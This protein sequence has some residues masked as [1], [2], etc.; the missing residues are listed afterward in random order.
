MESI[1]RGYRITTTP[2]QG[3][4][5]VCLDATIQ[6]QRVASPPPDMPALARFPAPQ[7]VDPPPHAVREIATALADAKNPLILIG[8]VSNDRAAFAQRVELAERLNARVLTDLKTAASF[9]TEHPLHPFAAGLYVS[10][11]AGAMIRE[12][13][14]IL[15]LD[16]IDLGGSL[17]QACAGGFPSAKILQCSM[18]SYSHKGWSM[19][20]QA[21]P[22]ADTLLL[23]S[24][25]RLVN[26]LLE[27]VP[28]K[29]LRPI[30]APAAA[31]AKPATTAARQTTVSCRLS[32]KSACRSTPWHASLQTRS[33]ASTLRTSACHWGGLASIADLPIRS[34]SSASMVAAESVQDR[35]WPSAL[36]LRCAERA[37]FPWPCWATETI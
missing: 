26:A 18:D 29:K 20:Y 33:M 36:R 30:A 13:D 3:P 1:V 35:A 21:L 6:E 15:S 22:P 4:V 24:P 2:P 12:A 28:R 5:Y 37:A 32:V 16:W 25:D 10:A 9:P 11:E 34:T 14:V 7:E 19:D 27:A 23:A 31:R 8:R 17:R